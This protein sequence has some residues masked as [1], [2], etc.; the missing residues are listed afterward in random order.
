MLAG[1]DWSPA[2]FAPYAE[3]RAE[4]MRRL[5]FVAALASM[6]DSEFGPEAEERRRRA[7]ANR[8]KD[9]TLTL[10]AFSVMVGPENMP[11]WAFEPEIIEKTFA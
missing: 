3:E 10:A 9:P 6:V 2:A 5:R 4:R 7:N 11:P 1:D 8:A